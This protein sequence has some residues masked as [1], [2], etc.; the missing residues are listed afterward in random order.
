MTIAPKK[1]VCYSRND[2]TIETL[3]KKGIEV[4]VFDH[5]ELSRGRGGARCMSMP[6]VRESIG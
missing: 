5:S 2:I 3:L 1:V 6:V 4:Q